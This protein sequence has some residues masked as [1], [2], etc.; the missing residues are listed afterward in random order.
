VR[1]T[2]RRALMVSHQGAANDRPSSSGIL[3]RLFTSEESGF[4]CL[5]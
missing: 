5:L 2:S 1:W 3:V 4:S